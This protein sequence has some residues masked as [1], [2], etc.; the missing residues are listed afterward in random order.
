NGM[1]AIAP[2]KR[3][4]AI[5]RAVDG[6]PN[7]KLPIYYYQLAESETLAFRLDEAEATAREGLRIAVAMNGEDHIHAMRLHL[8]LGD[9]L[10]ASDRVREGLEQVLEAKAQLPGLVARTDSLH[11]PVILRAS[12]IAL[13]K[14]GDF[15][16]ALEDLQSSLGLVRT[17]GKLPLIA[18]NTLEDIADVLMDLGRVA[19]ARAAF[20]EAADIRRDIAQK[21]SRRTTYIAARLAESEGRADEA[22]ALLGEVGAD[23]AASP[24]E[25]VAQLVRATLAARIELEAGRLDEAKRLAASAS[26]ITRDADF[27]AALETKI[28]ASE[29]VEGL[30][31][32]RGGYASGARPLLERT[33]ATREAKLLPKSPLIAEAELALAECDV[34]EGRRAS[35]LA[36]VERA[37]MIEE[38]HSSLSAEYTEP[39]ARLRAALRARP[40]THAPSAS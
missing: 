40:A 36:R 39:L 20:D 11:R 38:Q 21:A 29:L 17:I 5:S 25:T 16:G 32:L 33:L 22:L 28:A 19:A 2:L 37:A 12:G 31:M 30:A 24:S 27:V 13:F 18:A 34:A 14:A 23:P 1:D 9:V 26:A 35:A 7:P 3:A 6:V 15:D 4:I 8:K 10:L